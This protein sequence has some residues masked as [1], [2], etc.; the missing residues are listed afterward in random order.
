MNSLVNRFVSSVHAVTIFS[1]SAYYWLTI[2]TELSIASEMGSY[3][4]LSILIM[5]GYL[6]YD[7]FFELAASGGQ[8]DTIGHHLMGLLSHATAVYTG[9]SASAFYT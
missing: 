7:T 4:R 5:M 3:E 1:V 9:N 8:L 2:N 6:V